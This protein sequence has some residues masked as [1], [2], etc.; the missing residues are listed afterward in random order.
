MDD[1]RE[2]IEDLDDEFLENIL[3]D[4]TIELSNIERYLMNNYLSLGDPEKMD[5]ILDATNKINLLCQQTFL[6]PLHA[7]IQIIEDFFHQAC[8]GQ[9]GHSQWLSELMLLLMDEVRASFEDLTFRRTLDVLLLDEFRQQIKALMTQTVAPYEH[10]I[11]A[12]ISA[13]SCRVHPDLVFGAF[14][15]DQLTAPL[16]VKSTPN[17]MLDV[18]I[19]G[20]AIRTFEEFSAALDARSSHWEGRTMK[21]IEYCILIN[22]Q[23]PCP[24]NEQQLIAAVHMHDVGMGLLP[25]AYLFKKE[26]YDSIEVMLLQQHPL[27]MYGLM[28]QMPDWQ[29]AAL[30]VYQH[31]EHFNGKGYPNGITGKDTHTGAQIIAVADAFYSLTNNRTDRGYKR[32]LNRSLSEINKCNS[33]QFAPQIVEAFNAALVDKAKNT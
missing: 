14:E 1:V 5:Q 32:S 10:P 22:Q 15:P 13:F 31:H 17:T 23:L 25:D 11:K 7:Y 2:I 16:D 27:Q 19:N 28:R 26:K 9:F 18:D 30:M 6:G 20:D 12:V 4:L 29:E 33:T 24:V 3:E 21:I 8:E